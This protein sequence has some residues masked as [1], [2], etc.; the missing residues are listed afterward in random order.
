MCH[1]K[2]IPDQPSNAVSAALDQL[3]LPCLLNIYQAK[4]SMC[5]EADSSWGIYMAKENTWFVT[6]TLGEF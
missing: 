4:E 5:L 2:D 1:L 6:W 3:F